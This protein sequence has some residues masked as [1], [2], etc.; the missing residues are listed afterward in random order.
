MKVKTLG[1]LILF[2]LFFCAAP[3]WSEKVQVASV[4]SAV[5]IEGN[6]TISDGDILG[7]I[8]SRTGDI[9][10]QDKIKEDLKSIN[11]LGAFS[12]VS[13]KFESKPGGTKVI[14]TVVEN[15]QI[16]NIIFDGG[17][18]YSTAEFLSMISTKQGS[19]LNYKNL[20]EDIGKINNRYKT[21]GYILAKVIDVNVDEKTGILRFK[22]VEG[23]V[24]SVNLE[25]NESTKNYVILREMLTKPGKVLNEK[26]LKKDLR[27]VFNLG[28]FS[29]V[30]PSFQPGLDKNKVSLLLNIKETR[31]S[32]VNFGGGYGE[33]D[34]WF[35]FAD[36]SINNLLGTAQG[37]MI[38]GQAGQQLNSYQFRYT[39]PWFM[40]EKLGDRTALTFRK[41]LTRGRDIYITEQD[42][43][44]NGWDIS[45]G[46]PFMDYNNITWTIGSE[47]VNPLDTATFEAYQSDT[48]GVTFAYDTR[49]F[50]L[51]PKEGRYYTL[52]LKQGWKRAAS[53]N[54]AFFK[55]GGD[56]NYYQPFFDNQ[57][58][59]MHGGFGVGFD[60]VPV[61][62]EYWAG[63]ANTV[64]GYYPAEAHKGKRKLII[65]VEYR[66]NFSD[67]FQ[68]VFF[69]D[70]GNAWNAGAPV[71]SD[72]LSGWGP[73]VR[74][75]TPLGP[76]RLDWGVPKGKQ[77]GE[78]IMH[79]S[80]GQAF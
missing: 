52:A 58:L 24:E 2:L 69:Y 10:S 20:Q 32:T 31:S 26:N 72:F 39:N 25:G 33:R 55:I 62:E 61:G 14:F 12:D 56:L 65:N 7:A 34:G 49:D 35:G 54:S 44:Y 37:L 77:F 4:I 43:R 5:E 63:S 16:K 11:D 21:D 36:L 66:V 73:G 57:V 80:I 75:N 17:T 71:P 18:V 38:R 46:K 23:V 22:I 13:V 68:G 40:P 8:F 59:A 48:I 15:P 76:I 79:F 30:N 67:V 50:W 70:W 1:L 28:F 19:L 27:N 6:K 51:N 3:S 60:D 53:G 29:E 45:L 42:G 9:L 78:G 64:R 47:L 74:V 41:W